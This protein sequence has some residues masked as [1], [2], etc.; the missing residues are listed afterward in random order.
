MSNPVPNVNTYLVQVENR[1][2]KVHR[3]H[4][5]QESKVFH[6]MFSVPTEGAEVEGMN[7]DRPIRLPDVTVKEF[8][9]L[10]N[11]L[12]NL[13][14]QSKLY[15]PWCQQWLID[16]LTC[17]RPCSGNDNARIK[18]NQEDNLSL[19]GIAHRFVF[20]GIF[21]LIVKELE[22]VT[23]PLITRI[24]LGQKYELEEWLVSAYETLLARHESLNLDEAA[25]L[26]PDRVICFIKARDY[27]HRERL[28]IA[29]EELRQER[30]RVEHL[31]RRPKSR[32]RVDNFG[33]LSWGF[34]DPKG[35]HPVAS[36]RMPTTTAAVTR[37]F[38]R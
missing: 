18:A 38:F 29:Q 8:E 31:E 2:F 37:M 25:A 20:D 23:V 4:L 22:P 17:S 9:L 33:D 24:R 11:H 7:D 3:Y 5:I 15:L 6:D 21:Q 14:V 35:D 13:L 12:Y 27:I 16:D 30:D 10:L 36:I 1:L 28:E 19:L 32:K 26:G 34:S